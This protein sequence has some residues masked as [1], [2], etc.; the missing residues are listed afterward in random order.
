MKADIIVIGAGPAGMAA[1]WAAAKNGADT[2]LIERYGFCGGMATTGIIGS[3][4]GHY[5]NEKEPAVAGFLKALVEKTAE[6]DGCEKWE[7]AFKKYGISFDS[8]IL[9]YAAE[10]LLLDAGV[11]FL[12]HSYFVSSCV[13]EGNI[14]SIEIANKK[15]KMTVEGKYFIDATGDA[16]IAYFS[17][18]ECTKGRPQDGNT[19]SIG[20]IFKIA[21][22]DEEKLTD[23]VVKKAREQLA[24][25]RNS[26]E[27]K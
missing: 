13:N 5:L 4:L 18:F 15:G 9:K 6:L 8:E 23:D 14:K 22:I 1:A 21:G 11:R 19:E 16:D 3:I 12:Y 17:G 20:C 25:L 24:E 7:T 27:L 10:Q 26:G 2:L